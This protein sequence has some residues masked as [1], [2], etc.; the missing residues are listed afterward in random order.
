MYLLPLSFF[1]GYSL[2]AYDVFTY[3]TNSL[4]YEAIDKNSNIY[5]GVETY[6]LNRFKGTFAYTS[7]HKSGTIYSPLITTGGTLNFRQNQVYANLSASFFP[8]WEISVFSHNAFYNTAVTRGMPGNVN[9]LN[10]TITES[11]WGAGISKNLWKI[12][13]GANISFSNFSYSKQI[14]GE[15]YFTWLPAGNMNLYLTSG[16]MNQNDNKWGATYQVSQEIGLKIFKS[17]WLESG[18]IKGNS[19]LYGRNQG[20]MINNSYLIPETTI[21][22]NVIILPG[23]H[24]KLTLMPFYSENQGYSWDLNAFTRTNKIKINSFGGLIKLT[25]K[26]R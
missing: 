3:Q 10:K 2:T 22:G 14:R 5:A 1:L 24:L 8:G 12:R 25:Y 11:L 4:N 7:F 13:M 21:Y 17:M 23:R 6:F 15:G 26:Y 20:S 16:F 18:L 9:I 19:F